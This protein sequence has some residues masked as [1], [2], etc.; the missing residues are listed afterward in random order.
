MILLRA[1]SARLPSPQR[2]VRARLRPGDFPPGG[3][4]SNI[5]AGCSGSGGEARSCPQY[6]GHCPQPGRLHYSPK[7][8]PF[9]DGRHFME[10]AGD[11]ESPES[12]RRSGQPWQCPGPTCPA[13]TCPDLP[14]PA[15]SQPAATSGRAGCPAPTVPQSAWIRPD[16]SRP[17]TPAWT[18]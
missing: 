4:D 18:V 2:R 8:S 6:C 11:S 10:S 16:L 3:K 13:P 12:G 7:R 9:Q 14:C 5:T 17:A 1:T 15:G